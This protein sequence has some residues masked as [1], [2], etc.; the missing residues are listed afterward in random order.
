MDF[1][2]ERL[3]QDLSSS[4]TGQVHGLLHFNQTK[5]KYMFSESQTGTGLSNLCYANSAIKLVETRTHLGVTLTH[6][7]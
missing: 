5:I 4:I 2:E 1:I 7:L 6:M 3:N